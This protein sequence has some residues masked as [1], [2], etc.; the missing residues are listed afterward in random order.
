MKPFTK[1]QLPTTVA[2]RL[3]FVMTLLQGFPIC[4]ENGEPTGEYTPPVI[5]KA[6]ALKLLEEVDDAR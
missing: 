6:T 3:E 5:T 1:S 2:G 4:D